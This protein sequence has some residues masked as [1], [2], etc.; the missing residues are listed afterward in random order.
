MHMPSQRHLNSRHRFEI[1]ER[2]IMAHFESFIDITIRPFHF[3]WK[4]L[5]Q[6][7]RSLWFVYYFWT[8]YSSKLCGTGSSLTNHETTNH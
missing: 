7:M 3:D 4:L 8:I 2:T 6:I 1:S 5:F